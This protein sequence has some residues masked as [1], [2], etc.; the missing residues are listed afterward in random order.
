MSAFHFDLPQTNPRT[1]F[2]QTPHGN[3]HTPNFMP[4]ATRGA[5]RGIPIYLM[6]ELG[7]EILLSNA[8]HLYLKPGH[9]L[10]KSCAGSLRQFM[11][12]DG[13]ILTDSG[14]YQ[15]FSLA[16]LRAITSSHIQF[17]S[18]YD[19]SS[20]TYS[21]ELVVQIQSSLGSTFM[22]QLDELHPYG[23]DSETLKS[24]ISTTL[25]W[26]ALSQNLCRTIEH[27]GMLV[28][29]LQGG[30]NPEL[31]ALHIEK[32]DPMPPMVAIGGLAVGEPTAVFQEVLAHTMDRMPKDRL[33]Y[34]MGIGKPED[35]IFAIQ[36]GVDL[37][38]CVLPTRNGRNGQV[39]TFHG[40]YNI[41]NL[42]YRED[43]GP[44]EPDCTCPTCSTY[45]RAAIHHFFKVHEMNGPSA[46]S[47]HNLFF[48]FTLFSRI[49]S[50]I[51]SGTYDVFSR[52]FLDAYCHETISKG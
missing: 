13:P 22:M 10:I 51:A 20:H 23:T 43:M 37:F 17:Q 21:P 18:P 48:F 46:I 9:E 38:D 39:F 52:S 28:P 41:R 7:C 49:R 4:V 11:G 33:V 35:L 27:E 2:V 31:R 42:Q 26:Y 45:S 36:H 1:G 25:D 47:I 3:F 8:F 6:K 15:V 29:I 24:A 16:K 32:L 40:K 12:W 19:G 30:C 50:S 5:L 34:L 14:G 44:L